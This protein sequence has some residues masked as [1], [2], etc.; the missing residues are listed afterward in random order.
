GT[1]ARRAGHRHPVHL[2]RPRRRAHARR[3]RDRPLGRPRRRVRPVCAGAHRTPPRV[4]GAAGGGGAARELHDHRRLCRRGQH[5]MTAAS[6]ID[7]VAD[8]IAIAEELARLGVPDERVQRWQLARDPYRPEVTVETDAAG[9]LQ[10]AALTT[11]RP[12]TAATKI[13]DLW[14]RGEDA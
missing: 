3:H 5:R 9:T 12:A 1:P 14:W 10:A 2:A 8:A 7:S 6:R 11:A 13:V 4:H